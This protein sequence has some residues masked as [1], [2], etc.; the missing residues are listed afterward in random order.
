[1]DPTIKQMIDG[2]AVGF[3]AH[4]ARLGAEHPKFQ[5]AAAIYEELRRAGET[6]TDIGSFFAAAGGL[7]E[8][9]GGALA[10]LGEVPT[11]DGGGGGVGP[12]NASGQIA[13]LVSPYRARYQSLDRGR[14]EGL[15]AA[16]LCERV[17]ELESQAASVP[18]LLGRLAKEAIPGRLAALQHRIIARDA[19]AS[20]AGLS[21]PCMEHHYA[22]LA[23]TLEQVRTETEL[24]F[25]TNRLV[26]L[27]SVEGEWDT[28][29]VHY[30][31]KAIHETV[32]LLMDQSPTQQ[33]TV[34]NSY[35]FV[36]DFFGRDWG[37]MWSHPRVWSFWTMEFEKTRAT[38]VS[39]RSCHT[40]EQARD[41]LTK[42]FEGVMQGR[43]PVTM[44]SPD[45]Q[46]LMMW[47]RS[48]HLDS[49]PEVYRDPP[50]PAVDF[51]E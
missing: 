15:A 12:G 50:R 44:G 33:Q 49:V 2:Y 27:S 7:F 40:P 4:R 24:E 35:R 39:E 43:G 6:A 16:A 41:F 10:A 14:P 38:W 20:L 29:L 13:M 8:Q 34:E 26:E 5:E 32:G 19:G 51:T 18:D 1:M 46:N 23:G 17:F 3:D 37:T 48:L 28:L 9:V 45:G 30:L 22:A 11:P 21:Q 47:D 31:M 36:C 25:E 42:V